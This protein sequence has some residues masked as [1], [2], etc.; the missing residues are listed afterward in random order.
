MTIDGFDA[1]LDAALPRRTLVVGVLNV[2]PD[3]F[4]DGGRFLTADAALGHARQMLGDGA[5]IIDIGG[6]STRPGSA[7]VDPG[8]QM[9][10]VL[11][12]IRAVR[13]SGAV[14]SI[15]TT[16]S[17]VA[18]AAIDAGASIVNDVSGGVDDGAMPKAMCRARAAVLMHR[19]GP[20]ATMQQ[21]TEYGDVV[22]EVR[23][24]L[25]RQVQVVAREGLS[26]ARIFLDPGIGFGKTL[27]QNLRLLRELRRLTEGPCPVFVGTSRKRFIG[28][29]TGEPEAG[30]RLLGTAA[31]VAWSV[32]AG[33]AAVRVHDVRAMRQTV[34]MVEAIMR[35]DAVSEDALR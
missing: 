11:P 20:S 15:D 16:R 32:A 1:W 4:S 3:S 10:R 13:D 12:V 9:R 2:T 34:D 5:D 28:A 8:E 21:Q 31:T 23:Q 18:E 19:P 24:F 17:E 6:E 35:P 7:P 29:I 25:G 14:I 33:A 30:N 27:Q 22:E 26:E